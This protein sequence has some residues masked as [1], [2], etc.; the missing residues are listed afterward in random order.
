MLSF[1][2]KYKK[3]ADA[4]FFGPFYQ[5]FG[6]FK[7]EKIGKN[8]KNIRKIAIFLM[9]CTIFSKVIALCNMLIISTFC[10]SK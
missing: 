3:S 1:F 7:M 9:L 6:L 8:Q 10:A 4:R 5:F 2:K